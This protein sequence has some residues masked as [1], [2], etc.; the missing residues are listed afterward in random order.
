M[1]ITT[2]ITITTT[3]TTT[4]T[5]VI[6]NTISTISINLLGFTAVTFA[7]HPPQ[8]LFDEYAR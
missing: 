6:G 3:T 5:I 2:T 4:I 7:K 8:L 1:T